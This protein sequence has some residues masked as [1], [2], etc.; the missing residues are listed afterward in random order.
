MLNS[1]AYDNDILDTLFNT[2]WEEQKINAMKAVE[3]KNS[4]PLKTAADVIELLVAD[5]NTR[6]KKHKNQQGEKCVMTPEISLCGSETQEL[7]G[8][9][10]L[11]LEKQGLEKQPLFEN[12]AEDQRPRETVTGNA[13]ECPQSESEC[14]GSEDDEE[15][16]QCSAADLDTGCFAHLDC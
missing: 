10:N 7:C 2:R 8:W 16:P 15:M 5:Y 12:N 1:S 11:G 4:N 6:K 9:V 14:Q 13:T 3:P